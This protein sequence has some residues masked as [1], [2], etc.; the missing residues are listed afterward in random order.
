MAAYLELLNDCRQ[1]QIV[2]KTNAVRNPDDSGRGNREEYAYF[3]VILQ[4]NK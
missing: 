1:L 2:W 3:R 4:E